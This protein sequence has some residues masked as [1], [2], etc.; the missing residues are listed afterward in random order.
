MGNSESHPAQSQ[1]GF[2]IPKRRSPE[3][4]DESW[5]MVIARDEHNPFTTGTKK[6]ADYVGPPKECDVDSVDTYAC[7]AHA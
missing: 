5:P 6:H 4:M 2:R 7:V 1:S 3:D